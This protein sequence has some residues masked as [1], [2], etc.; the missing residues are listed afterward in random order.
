ML[1]VATANSLDTIQPALLDRMEIIDLHGYSVEEKT[2][3]GKKYLIP[4]QRKAHGLKGTQF[5]LSDAAIVSIIEQYTRESGVRSLDKKIAAVA[6][7]VAKKIASEEEVK[8][9]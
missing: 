4:K 9:V 5:K 3:I 8:K 1:F 2:Q 6:R 7:F